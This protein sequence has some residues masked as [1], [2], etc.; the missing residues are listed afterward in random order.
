[1]HDSFMANRPDYVRAVASSR[2]KNPI[3]GPLHLDVDTHPQQSTETPLIRQNHMQDHLKSYQDEARWVTDADTAQS[4]QAM[5]ALGANA[6]QL[7]IIS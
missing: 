2:E 1:M 4:I 3:I 7:T 5:R 6:E